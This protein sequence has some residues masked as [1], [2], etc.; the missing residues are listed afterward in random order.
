MRKGVVD[1]RSKRRFPINLTVRYR[2]LNRRDA[3]CGVGSTVNVS[4]KGL[5]ISGPGGVE[6]G[7]RI[8]V[9]MEWPFVLGGRIPLQLVTRGQIVRQE[10]SSFAVTFKRYQ[11][12]TR[13]PLNSAFL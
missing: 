2:S 9:T 13:R 3:F 6:L 12:R 11:L 10:E 4:S 8:E 7:A 1:R 5:L